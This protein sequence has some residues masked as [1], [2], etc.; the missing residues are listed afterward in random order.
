[1]TAKKTRNFWN[2]A[3][4]PL[5]VRLV[6]LMCTLVLI[7]LVLSAVAGSAALSRYLMQRV[8]AQ[9]VDM[10]HGPIGAQLGNA[11]RGSRGIDGVDG[12]DI[13]TGVTAEAYYTQVIISG[14][15]VFARLRKPPTSDQSEPS[16]RSAD[17]AYLLQRE[18]RPFSVHPVGEGSNWRVYIATRDQ[19]RVIVTVA[20]TTT[21]VTSTVNRLLFINGLVGGLVLLLLS[22][23][24][25]ISLR[26]TL[27][28]LRTVES[29][30]RAI[31]QGELSLRVPEFGERTEMGSLSRSIN[32]MLATIESTFDEEQRAKHEAIA[33]QQRMQ[34]FV[35]D[36]SHEL[37]T[38]LTSIRGFAE[39]AR[40]EKSMDLHTQIDFMHRIENEA[41]RMTVLVE[42]LLALA[43]LDQQRQLAEERID[44]GE[45]TEDVVESTRLIHNSHVIAWKA[46]PVATAWVTGDALCLRQVVNNLL[47]NAI[48]HTPVGTTIDVSV[49]VG[50]SLD[51]PD[52]L[53]ATNSSVTLAVVDNGPGIGESHRASIFERFYRV[54]QSRTRAHGGSGLGLS[55]AAELVHAQRGE[56]ELQDR[57]DGKTGAVFLARF[58]L[59]KRPGDAQ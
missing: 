44:L 1:M 48:V 10:A 56:I 6:V 31:A 52:H 38:P 19:G 28:G 43:R 24:G 25:Y 50:T 9:L 41:K 20:R 55:I 39:L 45:L 33:S 16:T 54:D 12:D 7:A 58:P 4:V 15:Q 36:A 17:A 42:D 8:D 11:P 35:A 3:N 34:Q 59:A 5:R 29:T 27:K 51:E 46:P 2:S 37:R 23:I 40:H 57:A 13:D 32:T 49:S 30:A 26:K 14:E 21:D 53:D 47:T 22:V 18:G